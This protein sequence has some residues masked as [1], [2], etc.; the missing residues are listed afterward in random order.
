MEDK[1]TDNYATLQFEK[2][3]SKS[4]FLEICE[5]F[6]IDRIR[7]G[8]RTFD[9]SQAKGNRI[10]ASIDI[11]ISM[12]DANELAYQ[13]LSGKIAKARI[14]SANSEHGR[15]PLYKSKIGGG[16]D[17]NNVIRYRDFAIFPG[18]KGPYAIGANSGIG[19]Q[20]EKGLIQKAEKPDTKI[21]LPMSD[22][23]LRAFANAMKRA[24]ASYD[25]IKAIEFFKQKK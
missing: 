7:L 15:Q 8:F 5:C 2:F 4:S 1:V 23:D 22:E 24:I 21:F 14:D 17:R 3:D 12:R 13:I 25:T 20:D 11:Y 19:R 16:K 9:Q 6:D 10:I 18:T